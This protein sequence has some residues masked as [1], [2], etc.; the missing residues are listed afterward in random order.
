MRAELHREIVHQRF[1]AQKCWKLNRIFCFCRY[2]IF[3]GSISRS[4]LLF[5]YG[6]FF[7]RMIYLYNSMCCIFLYSSFQ[8]ILLSSAPWKKNTRKRCEK[9]ALFRIPLTAIM[10][11]ISTPKRW[12]NCEWP[13]RLSCTLVQ[14]VSRFTSRGY[15]KKRSHSCRAIAIG[16]W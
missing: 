15:R 9:E 11:A 10:S 13:T 16:E 5:Y 3:N 6:R 4:Y 2:K 7:H 12:G 8:V 1:K 14:P